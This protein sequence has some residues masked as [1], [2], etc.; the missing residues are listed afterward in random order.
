ME[1][2]LLEKVKQMKGRGGLEFPWINIFR[3]GAIKGSF[4]FITVKGKRDLFVPVRNLFLDQLTNNFE[5][6][7]GER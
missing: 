6:I 1:C 7:R 5:V 3:M 2:G 4:W